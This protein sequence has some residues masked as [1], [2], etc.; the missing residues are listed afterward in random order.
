[1]KCLIPSLAAVIMMVLAT[2]CNAATCVTQYISCQIP[3]VAAP[4]T[5]CYCNTPNGPITG[6]IIATQNPGQQSIQP[7]AFCCTPGGKLGPY[8]NYNTPVG[9][10][11]YGMTPYGIV[12]G[13]ACY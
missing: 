12:Y 7:P 1:M 10:P 13:Q 8:V 4:G 5:A 11:C 9:G 6:V 2:T 3:G